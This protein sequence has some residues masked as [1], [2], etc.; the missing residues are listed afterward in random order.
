MLA[1]I[2]E[3]AGPA[4]A[5]N[6]AAATLAP[7]PMPGVGTLPPHLSALNVSAASVGGVVSA[8]QTTLTHMQLQQPLAAAGAAAAAGEAVL[9]L[10]GTAGVTAWTTFVD[11]T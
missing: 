1:P 6:A 2:K 3:E 4:A 10:R 5:A 9:A 7:V 8:Q 11:T